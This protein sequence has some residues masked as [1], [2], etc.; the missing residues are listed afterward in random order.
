MIKGVIFDMDGLLVNTEPLW[1]QAETKIFN[2]LGAQL[3]PEMCKTMMGKRIDEVVAYW[4]EVFDITKPSK[5]EI[6][7]DIQDELE[8]QIREGIDLLPGIKHTL[9]CFFQ[10][11]Y[12]IGLASSSSPQIIRAVLET[13][14]IESY[15]DVVSSGQCE[16]YGKPH[17][18][19]FLTTL[20]N[21]KLQPGE[22]VAFEDSFYGG[23]AAKAANIRTI[24]VPG[25]EE[26][27]HTKFGF[28]D[29][30]LGSMEEFN[31]EM[32]YS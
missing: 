17:P 12:K 27:N 14:G 16:R 8:M 19:V 28:A 31:E 26:K 5:Q 18:A 2:Q 23:I 1:Q 10:Y 6:I 21:M 15:F 4:C 20:R 9:D 24:L 13:T 11:N 32:L 3:T 30:V 7:L 22:V 29:K 25:E